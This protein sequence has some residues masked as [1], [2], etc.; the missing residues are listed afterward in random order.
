[1][2]EYKVL[3]TG[4]REWHDWKAIYSTL[5]RLRRRALL[6]HGHPLVVIHGEARGADL[7]A[8]AY[9]TEHSVVE[10]GYPAQWDRYGKKAG[11]VRNRLMLDHEQP[12]LVVGFLMVGDF[13]RMRRS[14]TRDCLLA[15]DERR[16]PVLL[17]TC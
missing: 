13:E 4:S 2:P 7:I 11:A 5:D 9:A 3:V 15:A 12:A 8:K 10:R 6:L 17:V 16:V 1:M 14:G